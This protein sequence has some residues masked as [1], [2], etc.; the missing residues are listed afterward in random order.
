MPNAFPSQPQSSTRRESNARAPK[1]AG[2]YHKT[3]SSTLAATVALTGT[4]AMSPDPG[5]LPAAASPASVP[6]HAA[7]A[8]TNAPDALPQ[9]A[10]GQAAR[11]PSAG[12]RTARAARRAPSP[13]LRRSGPDL[14]L[15]GAPY[16]YV[17]VNAY[18]LNGQETGA[19]YPQAAIDSLFRAL[20]PT[21]LTRT[22]AWRSN[23]ADSLA[24]IIRSAERHGQKLILSLSE[25]AG[26]DSPRVTR[27][28][29]WFAQGFKRDLLPWVDEVVS[30]YRNSSAIGMWEIMNEPGNRGG[31]RGPVSTRTMK[32]FFDTVAARIKANDP[33]HLVETGTMDAKQWG[34]GNWI[35]LNSGPNI[36]V[37]SVHDY[38]DE[39]EHGAPVSWNFLDIRTKIA[40]VGKPVIIGEVGVRGADPGTGCIRD[41]KRRAV[42]YRQKFDSYFARGVDG[43]NIWN[44]YPRKSNQCDSGESLYNGDPTM[45]LLRRYPTR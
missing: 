11:T 1:R 22:W 7:P 26:W 36:D 37:M 3:L 33:H 5:T 20:P 17:G 10:P 18:G 29:A 12:P 24:P 44:W 6:G 43:I 19:P 14:I 15:D 25:G 42:I 30:R 23:G 4:L 2:S 13:T 27:T 45:Q 34:T 31:T 9:A 41:R 40:A 8:V 28:E 21:T 32:T 16:R 35:E 39:Y 38:A